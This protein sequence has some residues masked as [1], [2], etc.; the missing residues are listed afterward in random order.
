MVLDQVLPLSTVP[1]SPAVSQLNVTAKFL[2]GVVTHEAGHTFGERH[3]DTTN[4]VFNIMDSASVQS[5]QAFIGVGPDGI[6][7][8]PDDL[9][10]EFVEDEFANEGFIG[11]T[12]TPASLSFELA[13][14]TVS[15]AITGHVFNDANRD[16]V[17]TNDA[18][19]GG[20]IVYADANS[21]GQRDT[22]DPFDVTGP[23]GAFRL[24]VAPGA[25]YNV[26]AIT[27][28][29]FVNS[30]P[31]SQ[32]VAAGS[33]GV[34]FGFT[35]VV[36]DITGTKWADVN[37]NGLFDTNESGLGGVYIYLDLDGDNR[38]D[39]GEPS[40]TTDSNG[41]YSIDF[42]GPGT[43]TIREVVE[44]GFV[45]TFPAS[46]EH[47]VT[48]NGTALT[49][50]F[51][52]G[53]LPSRDYGDAPNSYLTTS[54]VGGPSHGIS[55]AIGLGAEVDEKLT[56]SQRRPLW[57]MTTITSMTKTVWLFFLRS[58]PA[59]REPFR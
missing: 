45:Q 57:V 29:Q 19:L 22:T 53:N 24:N 34:N 59:A 54:A 37:G 55:A 6:A 32:I 33:T 4:T 9:Q 30:V 31:R 38:P 44:P 15:S 58:D 52:F 13:T 12:N 26:I 35:K 28:A 47:I 39:L 43:Y 7:G 17:F 21:N 56:A 23:G 18:G 46:G 14:G 5:G 11:Y 48:F 50:N 20:V 49:D 41:Q 25:N 51:N 16:G 1:L 27:P 3:T 42:P 40:D 10:A 2:A 8:T 36:S